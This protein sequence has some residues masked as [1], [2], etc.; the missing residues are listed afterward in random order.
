MN[1]KKTFPLYR[2]FNLNRPA[3]YFLHLILLSL[4]FSFI[5]A[6]R[7]DESFNLWYQDILVKKHY[8]SNKTNNSNP[9]VILSIDD[10][11]YNY[12]L[13]NHGSLRIAISKLVLQ[14][15]K[16]IPK[17]VC[18]NVLFYGKGLSAE[19]IYLTAA[20]N[21]S[22]PIY[23]KAELTQD[24]HYFTPLDAIST[25]NPKFGF[26]YLNPSK[27]SSV[28]K[29][30]IAEDISG[31]GPQLDLSSQLTALIRNDISPPSF[32]FSKKIMTYTSPDHSLK[33]IRTDNQ[34]CISLRYY[35]KWQ[36]LTVLRALDVI[37]NKINPA[38]FYNKIILI[39]GT[40]SVFQNSY[41]TPIGPMPQSG[42][43]VNSIMTQLHEQPSLKSMRIKHSLFLIL[44]ITFIFFLL[45]FTGS[46]FIASLYSGISLFILHLLF[47]TFYQ[48]GILLPYGSIIISSI[49]PLF[50][51]WLGRYFNLTFQSYELI[52]IASTDPSTGLFNFRYFT[53]LLQRNFIKLKRKH[54]GIYL[55]GI[56]LVKKD[57]ETQNP[58]QEIESRLF[59]EIGQFLNHYSKKSFCGYSL[60]QS[61]F[62]IAFTRYSHIK[63]TLL[64]ELHQHLSDI[65]KRLNQQYEPRIAGVDS[66]VS[67]ISSSIHLISI[68]DI[69]LRDKYFINSHFIEYHP[70]NL[71]TNFPE[72]P[73]PLLPQNDMDYISMQIHED[74]EDLHLMKK[75]LS[76]SIQNSTINQKLSAMGQ[77]SSYYAHELKNPLHNLLNCVEILQD[78]QETPEEKS[79]ILGMLKSEL[80]RMVDLANKMRNH[81][82]PSDEKPSEVK[83]N[84]LIKSTLT[85][86][87][88]RFKEQ[89]IEAHIE[90]DESIPT[91]FVVA[92]QLK[93]VLVNLI[94]NAI[95][96]MPQGG[97]KITIE[98][99]HT[100]P[101]V[102]ITV[103]D[104]G[105]G[106]DALDMEKIFEVFYSTKKEKGTGMGLFACYNILQ[107]HGG[108]IT[109]QSTKGKGSC[110]EIIL[111][112]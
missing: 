73:D 78:P 61:R 50:Y 4:S 72:V 31:F 112:T 88:T 71:T 104:T 44:G 21:S 14:L 99:H 102:K 101:V 77:L 82:K 19:D 2:L 10:E 94:L 96:A 28:R 24:E 13:Q 47:W 5:C 17:G 43:L 98:T 106:I 39:E 93:Q 86:F 20:A 45:N 68:L 26:L 40:A 32:D 52:R 23:F 15:K 49:I 18:I 84:D 75:N 81:F 36:D 92:D 59:K 60:D 22:L 25:P 41:N 9:F 30:K 42:I 62:F 53:F 8:E 69:L 79:K 95:E 29:L 111:P 97:G 83:I 110:F 37:E 65:L 74:K 11:S 80:N 3:Y 58:S 7:Y 55:V 66:E 89:K 35:Q 34:K 33:S 109:V 51:S 100:P 12:M 105:V 56:Q 1:S 54:S 46:F 70:S 57:T 85:L 91:L 48:S 107:R 87:Q 27:D 6:N 64:S 90:P 38:I 103:A 16:F 63:S 108:S 76:K 67:K